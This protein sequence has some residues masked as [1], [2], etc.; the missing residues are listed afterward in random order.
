MLAER[1]HILGL[2]RREHD[3][4]PALYA[5]MLDRAYAAL[6]VPAPERVLVD[7]TPVALPRLRPGTSGDVRYPVPTRRRGVCGTTSWSRSSTT[8]GL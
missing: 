4:L 3:R 8:A 6:V 5:R 1:R 2:V 7:S